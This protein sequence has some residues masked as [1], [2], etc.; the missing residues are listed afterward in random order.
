MASKGQKIKKVALEERIRI[1]KEKI[2]GGKSYQYLAD[3]YDISRKT[4]ETWVYIYRRDG[5]LDIKKK[6]RMSEKEK[7]DY[8]TRYE[9][10]KKYLDYLK[11]VEQE[12]K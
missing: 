6:G 1:V 7:A 10:L 3:R 8:K 11:E 12:K 2:N 4:I 9:I 5:G